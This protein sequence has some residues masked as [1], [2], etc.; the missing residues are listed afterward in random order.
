MWQNYTLEFCWSLKNKRTK[1][2]AELIYQR[3]ILYQSLEQIEQ[4]AVKIVSDLKII[5]YKELVPKEVLIRRYGFL[6]AESLTGSKSLSD[7]IE[8]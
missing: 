1:L 8:A 2:F 6:E 3:F 4:Q 7:I 5:G